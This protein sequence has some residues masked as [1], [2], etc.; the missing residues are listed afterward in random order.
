[1]RGPVS[2]YWGRNRVRDAKIR[3]AKIRDAK[4]RDAK[5]RDAKIRDAS[6][7]RLYDFVKTPHN[8][9]VQSHAPLY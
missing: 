7:A 5:I 2:I 6:L 1:M 9:S 3:D 4:I 8:E